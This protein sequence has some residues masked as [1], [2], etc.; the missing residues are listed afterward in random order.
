MPIK[1]PCAY[2]Y[3]GVLLD[4]GGEDRYCP[5]HKA[6]VAAETGDFRETVEP[7]RKVYESSEWALARARIR[8]R[9]G[10]RCEFARGE[11]HALCGKAANT[12]HH[13]VKVRVIWNRAGRP[14]P[15]TSEWR[16]FLHL[17]CAPGNLLLLC[18]SHH[19]YLENQS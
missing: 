10:D 3:C 19:R 12:V 8:K 16:T 17:C 2:P 15:G 13:K 1:T 11:G 6:R 14:L 18:G 4:A 7:W 9:A 5:R